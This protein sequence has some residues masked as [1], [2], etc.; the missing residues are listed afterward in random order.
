MDLSIIILNYKTKGLVKQCIKSI[1]L[2]NLKMEYEIIIVDNASADSCVEMIK[3]NYIVSKDVNFKGQVKLIEA[4]ENV[5]YTVGNNLGIKEAS[6]EA[7][8]ILNPDITVLEGAVETMFEFL[9]NNSQVGMVGPKLINPDGTVQYSCYQFPQWYMPILRR[10]ILGKL[11]QA[12]RLLR[13][14]LMMDWDHNNERAVPWLLGACTMVKREALEQIGLMDE[15]FFLYNSD[16]DWCRRFWQANFAVYYLP[17]AEMVHYHQ[18]LSAEVPGLK[19]VFN[20]I[21]R[22]HIIDSIKY[23]AK[24]LGAKEPT[25][26]F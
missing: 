19:S 23:N 15:R 7:V 25:V 4:K 10:T 8:M 24:Y 3:Q 6:G 2:L 12:K 5:G 14:Y 20:K 21:T 1:G 18:R 13:N 17:A 9:K 16:I 11:P 26:N 22:I